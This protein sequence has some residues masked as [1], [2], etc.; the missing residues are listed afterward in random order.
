M[1]QGQ[2]SERNTKRI[3][4]AGISDVPFPASVL[5]CFYSTPKCSYGLN[6]VF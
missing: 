6:N 2:D 1:T 4:A 5:G 3:T